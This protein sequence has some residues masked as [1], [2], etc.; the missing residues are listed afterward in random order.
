[1][2]QLSSAKVS[3]R[4][5][6]LDMGQNDRGVHDEDGKHAQ[7]TARVAQYIAVDRPDMACAVK[8]A[9]EAMVNPG[10]LMQLRIVRIGRSLRGL[11]GASD[12]RSCQGQHVA[13][14]MRQNRGCARRRAPPRSSDIVSRSH[15]IGT[16]VVILLDRRRTHQCSSTREA[17]SWHH[18]R[19]RR[20]C[21]CVGRSAAVQWQASGLQVL[22]R[23][24]SLR[25]KVALGPG[26]D[27]SAS[28][29]GA[30]G[31]HGSEPNGLGHEVHSC[32]TKARSL[33]RLSK[34]TAKRMHDYG[35]VNEFRVGS[36]SEDWL[37]W[38]P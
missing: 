13:L 21:R 32:S 2:L 31:A 9:R 38:S 11:S 30:Q 1:M 10:K 23:T 34:H 20:S 16:V 3:P 7:A 25:G 24:T 19:V 36:L 17:T 18:E 29:R 26:R 37:H 28:S 15:V 12:T 35:A 14:A 6:T 8:T 27:H 4:Q 33:G 22:R 5:K